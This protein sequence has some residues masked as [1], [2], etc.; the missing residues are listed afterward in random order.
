MSVSSTGTIFCYSPTR[1]SLCNNF[2]HVY[3]CGSLPWRVISWRVPVVFPRREYLYKTPR[4]R[5]FFK[6]TLRTLSRFHHTRRSILRS[7]SM[8][9]I[10]WDPV[11]CP[12]LSRPPSRQCF[13]RVLLSLVDEACWRRLS[14]GVHANRASAHSFC[15]TSCIL[16]AYSDSSHI[17]HVFFFLF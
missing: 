10:R 17:F 1:L 14:C 15:A 9:S 16:A 11:P 12:A 3:Y 7:V 6:A 4:G 5:I 8:W 13:A 2:N